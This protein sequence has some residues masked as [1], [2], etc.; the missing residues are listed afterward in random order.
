M[1]NKSSVSPHWVISKLLLNE[2][3]SYEDTLRYVGCHCH[4]HGY[5]VPDYSKICTSLYCSQGKLPKVQ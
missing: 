2:I 5:A 4:G 1:T 3:P